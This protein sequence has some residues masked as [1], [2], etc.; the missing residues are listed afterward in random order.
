M[1]GIVL[2]VLIR[3]WNTEVVTVLRE[4]LETH[5]L[6]LM[7]GVPS[8]KGVDSPAFDG[9]CKYDGWLV[10][11]FCCVV[12]GP[13]LDWVVAAAAQ[14]ADLGIG[15]RGSEGIKFGIASEEFCTEFGGFEYTHAL[16]VAIGN[17]FEACE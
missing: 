11:L 16:E 5:F 14:L 8:F 15:K 4:V 1:E 6:L 3:D 12:G 7:S 9:V 2:E 10:G 13:D 17:R